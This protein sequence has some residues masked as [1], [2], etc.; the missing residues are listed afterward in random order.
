MGKQSASRPSSS[1]RPFPLSLFLYDLDAANQVLQPAP[2]LPEQLYST[3]N[4]GDTARGEVAL[5]RAVLEDAI[6][7]FQK[8]AGKDGRRVQRLASEAEEWLFADDYRWPF[9]F[10]NICAVL[11]LDP[12]YVRLGLRRWHQYDSMLTHKR[13][14]RPPVTR[15]SLKIAA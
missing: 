6:G 1:L 5:M 11:G 4:T 12:E 7:C 3:S 10:V 8:Y 2:I 9:S 15:R 14:A 13:R